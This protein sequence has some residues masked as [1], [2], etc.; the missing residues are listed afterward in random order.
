MY[1]RLVWRYNYH[2]VYNMF[3]HIYCTFYWLWRQ[4][5]S[6][7]KLKFQIILSCHLI[8]IYDPLILLLLGRRITRRSPPKW[9]FAGK[10]FISAIHVFKAKIH[11]GGDHVILLRRSNKIKGSYIWIRWHDKIIWNFD[12]VTEIDCLHNQ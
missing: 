10:K 2:K 8:Q 4:S 7:T 6:V 3:L 5:I 9:I 12:F 1:W 11:F